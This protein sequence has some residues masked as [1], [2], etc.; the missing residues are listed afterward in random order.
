MIFVA[1][2]K[3]RQACFVLARACKTYESIA[4]FIQAEKT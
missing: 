2:I 1:A 4:S 3:R